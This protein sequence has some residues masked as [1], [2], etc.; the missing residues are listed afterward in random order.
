MWSRQSMGRAK[1]VLATFSQKA[2]H[3]VKMKFAIFRMNVFD[4]L[5]TESHIDRVVINT[6][7][8]IAIIHDQREIVWHNVAWVALIGDVNPIDQSYER[9][10][11]YGTLA[12]TGGELGEDSG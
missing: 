9:G 6:L 10:D 4:Q 5:I 2:V 1:Y 12:V 7:Q 11:R 8:S 3:Q